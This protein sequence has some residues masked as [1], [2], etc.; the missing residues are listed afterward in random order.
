MYGKTTLLTF[1]TF[2]WAVQLAPLRSDC[3]AHFSPLSVFQNVITVIFQRTVLESRTFFNLRHH[4]F[5][6]VRLFE[7]HN[8][9]KF[10]V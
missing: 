4:Y 1:S 2:L 6:V 9:N 3:L 7:R 5:A 10:F 8:G